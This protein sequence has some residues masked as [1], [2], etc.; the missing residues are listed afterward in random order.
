M[1]LRTS[2]LST[3]LAWIVDREFRKSMIAPVPGTTYPVVLGATLGGE[4]DAVVPA[5][6][7]LTLRYDFKPASVN[8]FSQGAMRI[9]SNGEV[10]LDFTAKPTPVV[11]DDESASMDRG[12]EIHANIDD[13]ANTVVHFRGK[14]NQGKDSECV[15]I[16]VPASGDKGGYFVLEH[17]GTAIRGLRHV[18][19]DQASA[20]V[21]RCSKRSRRCAANVDD[22]DDEDVADCGGG[23]SNG[24]GSSGHRAKGCDGHVL[25]RVSLRRNTTKAKQQKLDHA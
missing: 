11:T 7:I 12:N 21:R 17:E 20:Q 14:Q 24:D 3:H 6:D 22:G 23:G 13:T 1:C 15:L 9:H 25:N 8:E 4:R 19:E 16:F 5:D 2:V 18:R 10:R